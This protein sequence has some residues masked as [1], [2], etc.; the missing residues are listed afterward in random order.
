MGDAGHLQAIC[1]ACLSMH[2]L[3]IQTSTHN[4]TS[5][6]AAASICDAHVS[7]PINNS[8][9]L[10]TV[11]TN[12]PNTML[13]DDQNIFVWLVGQYRF[14]ALLDNLLY[15]THTHTHTHTHTQT[16]THS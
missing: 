12:K 5:T 15:W 13:A 9:C 11:V 6:S 14:H 7:P 1:L 2:D 10:M 3:H 4:Q 16:H 8:Y